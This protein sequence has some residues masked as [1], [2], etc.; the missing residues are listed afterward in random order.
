MIRVDKN[1]IRV[2]KSRRDDSSVVNKLNSVM[3]SRRRRQEGAYLVSPLQGFRI[4][5]G[6]VFY[7]AIAPTELKGRM[8]GVSQGGTRGLA[9]L[10]ID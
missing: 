5:S 2:L 4:R 3:K 9:M 10:E 7:R 6:G 8:G 1:K